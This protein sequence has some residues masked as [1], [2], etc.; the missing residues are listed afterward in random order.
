MP[1]KVLTT[2]FRCRL[3]TAGARAISAGGRVRGR[4]GGMEGERGG[5]GQGRERRERGGRRE[6]GVEGEVARERGRGE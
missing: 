2:R 6:E 1:V 3:R 5:G 4:V